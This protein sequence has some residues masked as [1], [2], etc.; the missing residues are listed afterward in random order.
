VRSDLLRVRLGMVTAM[1]NVIEHYVP[2]KFGKRSGKWI[3]SEQR[4]KIIPFPATEKKSARE[5]AGLLA[6][7]E[8]N[9]A[10]LRNCSAYVCERIAR[11]RA[12]TNASERMW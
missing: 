9:G 2:E 11:K 10:E 7:R 1:A 4:G 6:L 8:S 12:H 5:P 3:P